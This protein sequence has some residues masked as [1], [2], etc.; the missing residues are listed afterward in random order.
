MTNNSKKD[1]K[2]PTDVVQRIKAG[3]TV[4]QQLRVQSES[5]TRKDIGDWR[6]AHQQAK[7]VENPQRSN[8]YNIYD[9]TIDLDNMVTGIVMRSKFGIMS[10]PFDI[11]AADGKSMDDT[12][13]IFDA[14]WF[15]QYMILALDAYY[16][17]H[18]LIELGDIV[19]ANGVMGFAGLRL[20]PRRHV[21]PEYGVL[22]RDVGD[23]PSRG[24]PYRSGPLQRGVV[25][26]GDPYDLGAYLRIA[27]SVIGKKN[28][29]IFWDNF[30]ERFGVP[31]LFAK[32]D[33]RDR[34]E[35]SRATNMLKNLGSNAW[36]VFGTG[37]TIDKVET[38]TGD[39]F[40]VF[41]RRIS[42]ADEQISI[43]L[44]GQTMSFTDGSSL[45]QAEVHERGF[46]EIKDKMAD[47]LAANINN[48]LIPVMAQNGFP[49]QGCRFVWDKAYQYSPEEM[50]KVET[51]LLQ[52]YKIR[53]DYFV[54]KYHIDIEGEKS[55]VPT[56]LNNERG[57][58][59]FFA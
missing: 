35:R 29:Q 4:I 46:K 45:S 30:A 38:S 13:R 59:D 12:R 11:V 32:V 22:L 17:G 33:S 43:A 50:L 16:Y 48:R 24:I 25:E 28:A 34:E 21:C 15:R 9:Y 3:T 52:Y 54:N 14:E 51:L 31:I 20:V 42:R 6:I 36:A 1:S 55:A 57:G 23:E 2:A 5:L 40:E 7:D 26:V 49:V 10:R 47:D 56:G 41:D 37:V 19:A 8:L 53:K 58:M 44:A 18:C 39:A 27:P